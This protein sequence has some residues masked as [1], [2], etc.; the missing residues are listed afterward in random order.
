MLIAQGKMN[1]KNIALSVL[2][3]FISFSVLATQTLRHGVLQAYWKAQWNDNATVNTPVLGFRYFWLSDQGH[4]NKVINIQVKGTQ[5]EKMAFV[6][7]NFSNIP[8]NFIKYREWYVNQPGS[9]LVNKVVTYIECNSDNYSASLISFRPSK[10]KRVP[11]MAGMESR[12]PCGGDGR[13]PWL[14]AYHL[15]PE[16]DKYNFKEWPD[17]NA[18]KTDSITRDDIVVKIST[19]NR[20]WIFAALYD[21]S[22]DD[23]MSEKRGYI[24]ISH[25]VPDN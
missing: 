19:I 12:A 10:N 5:Q 7:H 3:L 14:T 2:L 1:M 22:K 20:F 6:R 4:F 23:R 15:R 21:D 25:L 24:R 9:L 11:N 13:Y 8:D 18:N 16:W 17:D